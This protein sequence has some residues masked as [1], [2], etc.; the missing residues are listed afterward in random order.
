MRSGS[1]FHHGI[2]TG[3]SSRPDAMM[4]GK[5]ARRWNWTW[6]PSFVAAFGLQP[7]VDIDRRLE[8]LRST[9]EDEVAPSPPHVA[10]PIPSGV[11]FW[12][13]TLE[14]EMARPAAEREAK[15]EHV[16]RQRLEEE[17]R[18]ANK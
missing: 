11:E 9:F 4:I 16:M 8:E 6:T 3:L 15:R 5:W 2:L 12:K 1:P 14:G 7:W 10:R 13:A 18:K 17:L